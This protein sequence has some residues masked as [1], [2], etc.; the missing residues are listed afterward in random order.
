VKGLGPRTNAIAS[1]IRNIHT[2]ADLARFEKNAEQRQALSDEIRE[3]VRV[4]STELGRKLV[5]ERTGLDLS[6]LAPRNCH[7]R[8]SSGSRLESDGTSKPENR[9]IAGQAIGANI[10]LTR[11]Q[12]MW[13][14]SLRRLKRCIGGC[15]PCKCGRAFFD[16]TGIAAALAT[17]GWMGGFIGVDI[18][19]P[20]TPRKRTV[21]DELR[22]KIRDNELL[23]TAGTLIANS[24]AV[25]TAWKFLSNVPATILTSRTI[26]FWWLFGVTLQIAAGIL[27]RLR[28]VDPETP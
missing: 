3:A 18:E 21:A 28:A 6:N 20:L 14:W 24:S 5:A 2:L 19:R 8:L 10:P 15:L 13:P 17:L 1:T 26:G 4:R 16:A 9:R 7:H 27:V 22:E 12:T 25:V 11:S 23:S